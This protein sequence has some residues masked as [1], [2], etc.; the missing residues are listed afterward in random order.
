MRHQGIASNSIANENMRTLKGTNY[1]I[2]RQGIAANSLSIEN[3]R[4]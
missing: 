3:M 2:G 1:E 4:T